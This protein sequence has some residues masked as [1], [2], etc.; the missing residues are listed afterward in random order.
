MKFEYT[1]VEFVEGA[2]DV[3]VPQLTQFISNLMVKSSRMK[4]K[5][6]DRNPEKI[7]KFRE[8]FEIFK[9]TSLSMLLHLM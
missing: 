7:Q 6:I 8:I 3:R 9:L 2:R 4:N 5:K 1:N